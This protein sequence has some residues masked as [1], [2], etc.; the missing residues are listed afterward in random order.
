MNSDSSRVTPP[1]SSDAID[2][3]LKFENATLVAALDYWRSRC[4]GE[5]MPKRDDIDPLEMRGFIGKVALIEV[6]NDAAGAR[7]YRVRLAAKSLEDVYG[8]VT[9][10]TL[11]GFLEP[12]M[13]ERWRL[14][15]D[16][17][18]AAGVPVRHAGQV[19][20]QGKS[21]LHTEVLLA[22]LADD[23][24]RI[25]MLFLTVSFSMPSVA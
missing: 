23:S 5:A 19:A 20:F 17:V 24:G 8:P 2:F 11:S 7:N 22:P 6:E 4:R 25:A 15:F 21:W 13:E 3:E 9:G 14:L 18:V 1:L 10:K 12:D 16:A